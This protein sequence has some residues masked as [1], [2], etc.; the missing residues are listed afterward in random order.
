V[1]K[2]TAEGD[3]WILGRYLGI[4]TATPTQAL[5]IDGN[6]RIGGLIYDVNNQGG[7]NGQILQCTGTGIDWVDV[8]TINDNDWVISGNNMYSGVS[9]NVGIGT[10]NPGA[11]LELSTSSGDPNL[12]FDIGD[13]NKFALGV[14][15]SDGDRLKIGTTAIDT[16]TI[17]TIDSAGY[18]GIGITDPDDLDCKFVVDAA[19][20]IGKVGIG[21]MHR[22][23]WLDGGSDNL[24]AITHTGASTGTLYFGWWDNTAEVTKRHLNIKNSDGRIGI[25]TGSGAI[26]T[27]LHLARNDD[28][29]PFITLEE[30]T[31][32]PDAPDAGSEVRIYVQGDKFYIMFKDGDDTKRW[33]L[34]LAGDDDQEWQ[35]STN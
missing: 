35:L 34:D 11:L 7:T 27:M 3:S 2:I 18:V 6:I 30:A 29:Q 31:N 21:K 5:H 8:S 32:S 22:D 25:G 23:I 33:Y 1:N 19:G 26:D 12:I 24:A 4:G 20:S 13:T 10:T 28:L 15:D 16:N 9:G 14:D 17:L